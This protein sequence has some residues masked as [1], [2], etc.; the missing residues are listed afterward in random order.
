MKSKHLS[1][2]LKILYSAGRDDCF[3]IYDSFFLFSQYCIGT[4]CH[5]LLLSESQPTWSDEYCEFALP[6]FGYCQVPSQHKDHRVHPILVSGLLVTLPGGRWWGSSCLKV[7]GPKEAGDRTDRRHRTPAS[8]LQKR[9]A[10]REGIDGICK[11]TRQSHA[12]RWRG[13][14]FPTPRWPS[15]VDTDWFLW[16]RFGSHSPSTSALY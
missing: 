7:Q 5:K 6:H 16:E 9:Q 2:S 15:A 1:A 8:S 11:I 14:S 12:R 13:N 4:E 3:C 10:P